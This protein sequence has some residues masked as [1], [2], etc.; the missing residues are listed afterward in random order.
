[1][2]T[3][4]RLHWMDLACS[5]IVLRTSS[6]CNTFRSSTWWNNLL[7][8]TKPCL[9]ESKKG[10]RHLP[11]LRKW[12]GSTVCVF[13]SEGQPLTLLTWSQ[14]SHSA[15]YGEVPV[16]FPA[17]FPL[18]C[19]PSTVPFHSLASSPRNQARWRGNSCEGMP[20]QSPKDSTEGSEIPSTK[21]T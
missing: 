18:S 7:W 2:S 8:D 3:G 17:R 15:V 19:I 5:V 20:G 21:D 11:R 9:Q 4:R 14:G 6:E 1:M 12:W 16:I 10:Q 13:P